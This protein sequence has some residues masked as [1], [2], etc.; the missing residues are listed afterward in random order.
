MEYPKNNPLVPDR[1]I[2]INPLIEIP[3]KILKILFKKLVKRFVITI[4]IVYKYIGI[5]IYTHNDIH[6]IGDMKNEL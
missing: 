2:M 6:S 4:V 3:L 5:T 1:E